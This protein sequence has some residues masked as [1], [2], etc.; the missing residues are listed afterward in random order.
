MISVYL[1][2]DSVMDCTDK[3]ARFFKK[4]A[5]KYYECE[6]KLIYLPHEI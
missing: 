2:L 5:R 1:L 3:N 6:Q 4:N